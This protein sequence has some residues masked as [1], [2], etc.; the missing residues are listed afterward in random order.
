MTALIHRLEAAR[1][2]LAGQDADGRRAHPSM[3]DRDVISFAHGDGTRR[4]H[5]TVIEAGVRALLDTQDSSLDDYRFLQRHVE[6]EREIAREFERRGVPAEVASNVVV[7]CGTTSLFVSFLHAHSQPGDVFLVPRSYYHPMPSW[8]ELFDVDLELVVTQRRN[9]YRLTP[10]DVEEWVRAHPRAS[11]RTRGLFL[12]NPNQSGALYPPE[13]LAQLGRMI[14]ERDW[15]LVEDNVFAGTEF[16][17]EN[18]VRPCVA[19][20][21]EIAEHAVTLMGAS[22]TFNLANLRVGWACGPDRLVA[23]MERFRLT[24]LGNVSWLVQAMAAAAMRA[25]GHYLLRNAAECASRAYLIERL[26]HASNEALDSLLE[27]PAFEVEHFPQSGHGILLSADRLVAGLGL[28]PA[29]SGSIALARW[30]L[31]EARVAVSPGYSLGF[32]GTEVRLAFGS[33][34]LRESHAFVHEREAAAA[35]AALG[36]KPGNAG[37]EDARLFE[38]GRRLIERALLE[39]IVPAAE[40]VLA[41]QVAGRA[42]RR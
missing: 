14:A 13:E 36:W 34:G 29:P 23:P 3:L 9:D 22:K 7:D 1:R 30:L 33:T 18:P 39:R 20:M 21:P 28:D 5:H 12:L 31:S 38:P 26:V 24:A 25:P 16:P 35:A 4:P 11:A 40:R 8:C 42:G 10:E 19:V 15:L 27:G 32:D 41:R 17:G 37:E 2:V 6:L